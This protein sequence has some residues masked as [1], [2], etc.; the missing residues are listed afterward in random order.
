[1]GFSVAAQL[2][3]RCDYLRRAAQQ[4]ADLIHVLLRRRTG[5]QSQTC[6][7]CEPRGGDL[8]GPLGVLPAMDFGE[9]PQEAHVQDLIDR[10]LWG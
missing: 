5:S 4:D 2:C 3:L 8:Q 6:A 7:R 1:M 9:V 10:I